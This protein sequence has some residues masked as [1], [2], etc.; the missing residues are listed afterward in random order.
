VLVLDTDVLIAAL[1]S[2][3]GASAELVRRVLR[4]HVEIA[5][6]VAI[7]LEYEAVATRVEH[8]EASGLTVGEGVNVIDA[9]AARAK[10][11]ELS[12]RWRPQL[13]DPDDEMLLEAAV[14]AGAAVVT[15]NRRDFLPAAL[16]FGVELLLPVE[17]L[18]RS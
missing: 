1:R 10:P 13:R 15:F 17:A 11:V 12:F 3:T 2:R 5:A 9:L 16:M 14:N 4:G 6:T 18:R 7:I 8:V